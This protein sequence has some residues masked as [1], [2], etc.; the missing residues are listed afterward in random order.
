MIRI[1][2]LFSNFSLCSWD[3]SITVSSWRCSTEDLWLAMVTRGI[4][5]LMA[6]IL[7]PANTQLYPIGLSL[8]WRTTVMTRVSSGRQQTR[9]NP[10]KYARVTDRAM[11]G[12]IS[13]IATMSIV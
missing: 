12:H 5:T 7:R 3:Y 13:S 2:F 6:N 11:G 1:L 9:D 8:R 10:L 4:L